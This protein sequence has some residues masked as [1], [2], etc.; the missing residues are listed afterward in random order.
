M[1]VVKFDFFF[2]ICLHFDLPSERLFKQPAEI[3]KNMK[4]TCRPG[5]NS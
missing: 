2:L 5:T 3:V 4:Q 1:Y